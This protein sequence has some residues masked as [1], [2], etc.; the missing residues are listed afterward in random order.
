LFGI[1]Q[2]LIDPDLSRHCEGAITELRRRWTG[3]IFNSPPRTQ[4]AIAVETELIR[5][6]S[7]RYAVSNGK[8]RDLELLRAGAIGKGRTEMEQHWA[9]VEHDGDLVLQFFSG[10]RRV[11][12]LLRQQDGSWRGA[13]VGHPGFDARLLAEQ[14][15]LTWPNA[16]E[17]SVERTAEAELTALLDPCLF[18]SGFDFETEHELQGALS[19]L[20]RLRDDVP[21][22]ILAKLA[23]MK[24]SQDWRAALETFA[25]TLKEIRDARLNCTPQDSVAPVEINPQHYTRIF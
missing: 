7:F 16:K 22:L 20:N 11:V 2:Q 25:L 6:R 1:N 4:R 23:I 12:E 3:A 5:Q 19:L 8:P 9:V 18:A 24:L 21:E 10:S 17:E 15:W 14:E 13:S